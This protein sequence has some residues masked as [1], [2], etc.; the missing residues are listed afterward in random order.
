MSESRTINIVIAALGGEGGGV[1]ADWVTEVAAGGGYVAQSTSVPGVAQRTGATIYYLELFGRAGADDRQPVMSLFPTQGDVDIVVASETVEAGRMVQRGFVTPGR[2]TLITSDH[3]VY[4]I[5]EKI[6]AGSGVVDADE[7]R[8]IAAERARR[9]IHFDMLELARRHDTVISASLFGALAGSGALPFPREAFE[10]VIRHTGKAVEANLAA[11]GEAFEQ[12]ASG[13]VGSFTPAPVGETQPA[14]TLPKPTTPI[15]QRLLGRITAEF[16]PACQEILYHGV[17]RLLDYQD[18]AYAG[19]YL[20]RLAKLKPFEAGRDGE[21]IREAGRY[22]AL[23]M[24]YE[25]IVRVAQIKIDPARFERFRDE[26]GAAP[27]QYFYMVEFLRPQVEEFVSILPPK[28]A[29]GILGSKFWRGL[30]GRFTGGKFVTTNKVAGFMQF[31]LLAKLRPLRRHSW[32]YREENRRIDR[33]LDA[34]NRAAGESYD[35]AVELACCGRL[36]KGYGATR[37]R[38]RKSIAAILD[39]FDRGGVTAAQ[40][41]QWRESALKDTSGKALEVEQ[42]G[43]PVEA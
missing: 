7:L 9:F 26:I 36:M 24:A 34:I 40:V 5:G 3:R 21:L 42:A 17:K 23:W 14:F 13:G 12:A 38:S 43:E 8:G 4:A 1:L 11:F 33:W 35:L 18:E 10:A 19:S 15:G 20:D 39:A 22:L 16:D 2:T 41:S 6:A 29:E 27:D 32:Q 28:L 37:A 30:L 31:Y 25:D